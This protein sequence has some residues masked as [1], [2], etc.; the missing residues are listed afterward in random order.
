MNNPDRVKNQRAEFVAMGLLLS[1]VVALV[2]FAAIKPVPDPP[3]NNP[4]NSPAE[5]D[6]RENTLRH[7]RDMT[8]G[9]RW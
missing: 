8:G 4:S 2:T 7:L 9:V 5:Q 3:K 6:I 1:G